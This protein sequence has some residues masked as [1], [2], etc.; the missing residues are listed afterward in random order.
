MPQPY[1][2]LVWAVLAA[3]FA[4]LTSIFAKVGLRDVDPDYA[5][6]VRTAIILAITAV[7]VV[8][9][10]KW[11]PLSSLNVR[12]WLFLV[13]SALATGASWICFF[14]ALKIAD[15]SRVAPIDKLSV[16]MVA[17][18]AACFLGEKLGVTGWTGMALITAGAVLVAWTK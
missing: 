2:W 8:A 5:S 10:G 3:V 12:T 14:R 6:L 15:A 1:A 9:V 4:A 13:L 11:Q 16:V 7:V 17:V 18:F